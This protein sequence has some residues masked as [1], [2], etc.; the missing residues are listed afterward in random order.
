MFQATRTPER[1]A[2]GFSLVEVVVA[3]GIITFCVIAILSL[4]SLGLRNA[5]ESEGEIRA[6]NLALSIVGRMRAAPREDLTS[7]GFL[8]GPLT[9][10][11]GTLFS[12]S[13]SAPWYL[14]GDGL[15]A[16]NANA[17]MASNGYAV[18]AEGTFDATNKIAT[19]SFTLWW[20]PVAALT[21]ASGKYRV[22]TFID[23]SAP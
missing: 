15:R 10:G 19:V 20:P 1:V 2:V 22:S 9:N 11:G 3:L 14:R 13:S 4:F 16:T 12:V 7:Q 17:A 8:F 21:N 6:A 18:S 23:T 5:R